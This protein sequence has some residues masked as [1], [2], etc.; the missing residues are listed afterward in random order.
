ME[1]RVFS[2]Q[3]WCRKFKNGKE[4]TNDKVRPDA[5]KTA[6]TDRN[7]ACVEVLIR[8]NRRV[9]IKTI[10]ENV[11]VSTGTVYCIVHKLGY[12]KVCVQWFLVFFLRTKNTCKWACLCETSLSTPKM[13]MIFSCQ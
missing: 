10:A 6:S 1:T 13:V 2:I 7:I 11:G 3:E 8:E 9:S 4:G 5:L 12:T